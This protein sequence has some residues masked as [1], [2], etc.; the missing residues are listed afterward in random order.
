MD[1]ADSIS[2]RLTNKMNCFKCFQPK[3]E[4][5]G[6]SHGLSTKVIFHLTLCL[7]ELVT[8]II[9]YGYADYDEHPIDVTIRIDGDVIHISVIDDAEPFNIMEAPEPELDTPLEERE[10]PIG[11]MGIHIVKNMMDTIEYKREEDKNILLL[12]KKICDGC[13]PEEGQPA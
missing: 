4:E 7:D 1:M 6:E 8:N 5:L 9:D 2:F 3:V 13:C 11:G 10:R 12:S